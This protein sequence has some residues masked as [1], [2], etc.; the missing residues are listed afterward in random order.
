[1]FLRR[2]Y[3]TF[4]EKW[5]MFSTWGGVKWER[6]TPRLLNANEEILLGRSM[7]GLCAVVLILLTEITTEMVVQIHP[8]PKFL[9]NLQ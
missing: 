2:F 4:D 5:L 7:N 3:L 8:S 6:K 9:N 1:M